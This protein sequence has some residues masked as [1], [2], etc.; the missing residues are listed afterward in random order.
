[1][2]ENNREST[3]RNGVLIVFSLDHQPKAGSLDPFGE[4]RVFRRRSSQSTRAPSKSG[5][6]KTS[7]RLV[8]CSRGSG[9]FGSVFLRVPPFFAGLKGSQQEELQFW[10]DPLKYAGLTISKPG[11]RT[12]MATI[13][14]SG[15]GIHC[16][17]LSKLLIE[18]ELLPKCPWQGHFWSWHM[19]FPTE[20]HIA[21]AWPVERVPLNGSML[22]CEIL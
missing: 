10:E 16:C 22:R 13:E 3:P 4:A 6:A 14:V 9:L 17:V 7:S 11:S 8:G 19:F 5:V 21:V 2:V 1:M 18:T 20:L 15:A 12:P